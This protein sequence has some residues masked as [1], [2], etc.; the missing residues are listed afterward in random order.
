MLYSRIFNKLGDKA[1]LLCENVELRTFCVLFFLE[2]EVL[3]R[4]FA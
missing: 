1:V 2:R 4:N 3:R